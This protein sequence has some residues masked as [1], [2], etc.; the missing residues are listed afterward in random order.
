MYIAPVTILAAF[1]QTRLYIGSTRQQIIMLYVEVLERREYAIRRQALNWNRNTNCNQFMDVIKGILCEILTQE[2]EL[3]WGGLQ[4]I[5][6]ID[7]Q[8]LA[9]GF[10]HAIHFRLKIGGIVYHIEIGMAHPGSRRLVVQLTGQLNALRATGVILKE[11]W[12]ISICKWV[13]ALSLFY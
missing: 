6:R 3:P 7:A 8:L 11:V 1:A 5:A 13:I 10:N 12:G 2:F 4:T 9:H